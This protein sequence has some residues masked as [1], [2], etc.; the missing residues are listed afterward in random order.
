MKLQI[1]L[2]RLTYEECFRILAQ[3]GGSVDII[4][5]GTGIIKE[6]GLGIVRDVKERYPRKSVL[7]DVKICDA[8]KSESET[9]F[10]YGAD[11]ITVMS[12]ADMNTIGACVEAAEARQKEVVVDLLNNKDPDVFDQLESI[13]VSSVSAHIGKDQQSGGAGHNPFFQ[14]LTDR[15]FKVYV[16]GGID[17]TNLDRYLNLNPAVVIVGSGITKAEDKKEKA[18]LIKKSLGKYN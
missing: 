6:Y 3:V 9:A 16:A 1:A 13:G 7:A 10:D 11:I 12:F 8:G 18:G 15:Y 2:D 4:E 5:V 17:E 14:E